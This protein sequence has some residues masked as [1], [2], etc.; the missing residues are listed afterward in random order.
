MSDREFQVASTPVETG[1]TFLEASAGTGKT[2][3]ISKLV[4]RLIAEK[5]LPISSVLVMTFTEAATRELKDRI[6][7]AIQETLL[8]IQQP[9]S[10]DTLAQHYRATEEDTK[11]IERRLRTA[12]ANFDEASIFTIHGFCH[13]V[14]N[15]F[16]FE[17]NR[18]FEA[19]PDQRAHSTPGMKPS[20]ITGA[21]RST[22]TMDSLHR[23]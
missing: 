23:F 11:R 16:A 10:E 21:K 14:L 18:L 2:Y 8:G 19:T 17:G 9:E 13:R 7:K 20:K 22:R 12:L 4:V 1:V 6:R 3:T 5:D 15:E